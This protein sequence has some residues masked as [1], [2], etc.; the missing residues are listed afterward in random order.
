MTQ[1]LRRKGFGEAAA[2]E[3]MARLQSAGYINDEGLSLELVRKAHDVKLLGAMGASMYLR[4]MGIPAQTAREAL[5][6]YD[7]AES[8]RTLVRRKMGSMRGLDRKV[9]RRRL[10]GYLARRGY[11]GS[12]AREAM[13]AVGMYNKQAPQEETSD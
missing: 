10:A 9:A 7:E 8:A 4:K 5:E 13:E 6:G 11:S 1:R 2:Q 3:A 12:T